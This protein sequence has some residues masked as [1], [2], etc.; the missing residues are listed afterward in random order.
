MRNRY[1]E[2]FMPGRMPTPMKDRRKRKKALLLAEL[3]VLCVLF[4]AGCAKKGVESL[5]GV[6]KEELQKQAAAEKYL[7]T[8]AMPDTWANWK[9]TWDELE[10]EYGI[11][12]QDIDMSS[13]EE[14]EIFRNQKKEGTKD[15]GDVGSSYA[16]QAEK[17]QL[18]LKYKTDYWEDIPEWAKDDDGDWI[19]CYTGNVSFLV[20]KNR[21]K[22]TPHSWQEVRD[23]DFLVTVGDVMAAVQSQYAVIAAAYA[24]GGSIDDLSPGIEFFKELAVEGRLDRQ[25][26]RLDRIAAGETELTV[27][28]DF[29]SLNYRKQAMEKEPSLSFDVTIPRDGS[30][31]LGYAAVIS[32]YAPHPHAAALAREFILSDQGQINLAKGF[33]RP[34]RDVQL[35]PEVQGQLIPEEEYAGVI[36]IADHE[37]IEKALREVTEVWANEV[38]PALQ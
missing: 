27:L 21:V 4:A 20:N 30:L 13:A 34:V 19:V 11:L 16:A 24:F 32:R 26:N 37:K 2:D 8:L 36:H 15:M 1:D 12:Q 33:A 7:Y 9:D 5:N 25:R 31:S 6:S 38:M 3:S 18:L 10:T 22:D 23:G 17:E 14:L 28:M 29:N 35:P